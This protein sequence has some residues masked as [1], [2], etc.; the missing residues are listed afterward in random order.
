MSSTKKKG[1]QKNLRENEVKYC[2]F[3][4]PGPDVPRFG[5]EEVGS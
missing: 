1:Q 4:F 3:T 2:N 5:N